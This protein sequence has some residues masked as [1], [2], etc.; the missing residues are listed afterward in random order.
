M[1]FLEISVAAEGPASSKDVSS[2][3]ENTKRQVIEDVDDLQLVSDFDETFF[4][5]KRKRK[6][7]LANM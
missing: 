5:L 3:D 7:Q 1:P 4:V 2:P 6:T